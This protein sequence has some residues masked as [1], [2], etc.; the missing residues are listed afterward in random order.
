MHRVAVGIEDRLNVAGEGRGARGE[1]SEGRGAGGEG[2]ECSARPSLLASRPSESPS[3]LVSRPSCTQTL[4]NGKAINSAK[5]PGRLTPT[6]CVSL[7]RCRRPAR[8]LR[9]RPQTTWPFAGD[10]FAGVKILDVGADLDDLA[11]EFMPDDERHGDGLL[12]PGVP[13]VDVQIG[14]A[15]AG[16]Q[17]L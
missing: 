7:H 1:G 2:R 15:D 9:Q 16:A 13:F 14:A 17:T 10:D 5:A 3:P 11:D 4:L 6:P 12:G 8:Q